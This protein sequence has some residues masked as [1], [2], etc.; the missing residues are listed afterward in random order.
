MGPAVFDTFA[1]RAGN[2]LEIFT[3]AL[4]GY[5][6]SQWLADGSIRQQVTQMAADMPAGHLLGWSLGGLYALDLYLQYPG[7]FSGLTLVCFNPCFV[8]RDDWSCGVDEEV[9]QQ[10]SEDLQHGWQATIRRFLSMQLHGQPDA[11]ST[12]RELTAALARAGV[13]D[14][15]ILYQ[16]L[17]MLQRGDCRDSLASADRP[18]QMIFSDRDPLVPADC[19]KQISQIAPTIRVECV[20][21]GSHLPF[22]SHADQFFNLL[23]VGF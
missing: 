15:R 7:Q 11:R 18:I 13:P 1:E 8:K 3:P 6:S 10:F 4:P 5:P 2:Q 12:V 14:D 9:F 21:G 17:D 19:A 23:T 20:A 22:L 16:G